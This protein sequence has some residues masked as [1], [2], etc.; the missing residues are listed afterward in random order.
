[1][2]QRVGRIALGEP[3]QVQGAG[4]AVADVSSPERQAALPGH[5]ARE[6]IVC[7]RRLEPVPLPQG[8][9]DIGG[10]RDHAIHLP[11]PGVHA[12]GAL[13]P[14]D[15]RPADVAHFAHAEP[16][17][18]HHQK[19]RTV[20]Q[21]IDHP[22]EGDDFGLRHRT[23][24]PRGYENLMARELHGRLHQEPLVTQEAK[25]ALQSTATGHDGPGRSPLL[26]GGGNPGSNI[27][28]RGLR[29]VLIERGLPTRGHQHC[30][31]CEGAERMVLR[32]R[33][34][35]AGAQMRQRGRHSCLVLGTEKVQPT[36]L[37]QGPERASGL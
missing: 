35:M 10:Q 11:F 14:I 32:R 31:T 13:G 25:E 23:G 28:G 8:G 19:H 33:R 4:H 2:P 26:E 3:R 37:W 7:R 1:M 17:P 12:Q 20:F 18:Q 34:I 16:A 5:P 24:E 30:A 27:S 36:E 6:D 29:Q 21:R 15:R 22:K 9:R